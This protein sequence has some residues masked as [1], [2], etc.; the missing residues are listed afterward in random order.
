MGTVR[1][2]PKHS[3]GPKGKRWNCPRGAA[4]VHN[5]ILQLIGR[6]NFG[7]VFSEKCKKSI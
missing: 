6:A 1:A 4:G 7:L 5:Y 3:E 2:F